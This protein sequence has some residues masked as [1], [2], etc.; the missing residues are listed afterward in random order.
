MSICSAQDVERKWGGKMRSIDADE[1]AK[2]L[3]ELYYDGECNKP[4]EMSQNY[5]YWSGVQD[6]TD[7]ILSCIEDAPTIDAVPVVHGKWSNAQTFSSSVLFRNGE[8]MREEQC[9][10]CGRWNT[11]LNRMIKTNYCPHCGAK[12]DGGTE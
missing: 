10:V 8:I 4:S 5:D 12:M 2:E 9:S 1:L 6:R 11:R 3:K 7:Y